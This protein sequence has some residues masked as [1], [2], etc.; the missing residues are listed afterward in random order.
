MEGSALVT[1][2]DILAANARYAGTA[3]L[4]EGA[5]PRRQVA[6]VTCMDVRID[7]LPALG[8]QPGE[9]HVIRNAGA[10]VTDDVIRSL[11][12]SQQALGTTH[13]VLMP[14]THCGLLAFEDDMVKPHAPVEGH[15]ACMGFRD[16]EEMLAGDLERLRRSPWIAKDAR[17]TALIFDVAS[18]R[19][20]PFGGEN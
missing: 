8:L 15:L 20:R 16:I 6:V 14:H 2:A 18:G 3:T 1:L 17:L 7:P 9:A 4:P 19:V 5:R 13:V 10:R 12:I 11:A